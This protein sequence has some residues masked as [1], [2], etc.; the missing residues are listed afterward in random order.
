MFPLDARHEFFLLCFLLLS[1]W[2]VFHPVCVV[3]PGHFLL[4]HLPCPCLF[5]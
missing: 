1:F 4:S 5:C 2:V 3:C